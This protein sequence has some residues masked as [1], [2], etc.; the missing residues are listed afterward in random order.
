MLK[1]I[2]L[3][4]AAAGLVL[5]S[6]EIHAQCKSKVSVWGSETCYYRLSD[7]ATTDY[8]IKVSVDS[9][10]ILDSKPGPASSVIKNVHRQLETKK[11]EYA[12]LI[13]SVD[14][15]NKND[16]QDCALYKIGENG[17][18]DETD[19]I[20]DPFTWDCV[21]DAV[22]FAYRITKLV[23]DRKDIPAPFFY[24][25][26]VSNDVDKVGK[27]P[28]GLSQLISNTVAMRELL[29]SYRDIYASANS[30][31][32]PVVSYTAQGNDSLWKI[33]AAQTGVAENWPVLWS[34]NS[35]NLG[36][37]D[38]IMVGTKLRVPAM[39]K[40]FTEVTYSSFEPAA[41]S[42]DVYGTEDLDS[43]VGWWCMSQ[44]DVWDA[45]CSLPRFEEFD[46]FD[47]IY[48]GH[49]DYLWDVQRQQ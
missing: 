6:S 2:A 45:K 49:P 15:A 14:R 3:S 27:V 5:A 42:S 37:S 32:F 44:S 9:L 22:A 33:A 4:V 46:E 43:F 13:F 40:D 30:V 36:D 26:H 34:F 11:L 16:T 10:E 38:V 35:D 7:T 25:Y 23:D 1:S 31:A 28:Y 24:T 48:L 21:H 41:I 12:G 39:I 20:V 8:L 47:A 17:V 18:Y 29:S 19:S